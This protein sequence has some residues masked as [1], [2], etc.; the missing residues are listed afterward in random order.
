M[1]EGVGDHGCE[2]MTGGICVIL[3]LTGRN[4]AAGMS[5][6]IAYVYDVDGMFDRRCNKAM[7]D[8]FMLE[9]EKEISK[10][11]ELIHEFNQRTGSEVADHI[12]NEWDTEVKKF[13]KVFPQEYQRVLKDRM[14]KKP[15]IPSR[16]ASP[17]TT[18][19]DPP[20][21]IEDLLPDPNK[22][23]KVRGFMKYK[24]IKTYYKEAKGRLNKWGEVY[25]F[26][27]IRDNVRVQASR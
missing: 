13:V 23:D 24:R 3:G 1:V 8:L 22:L 27:V 9:E 4:F 6:G 15:L 16:R 17:A 5:G 11:A 14:L 26:K 2:Y 7:V 12:L 10:L 25:D 18:P 20:K 21:D 19:S